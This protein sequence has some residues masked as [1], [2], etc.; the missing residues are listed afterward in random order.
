MLGTFIVKPSYILDSW[1]TC[2]KKNLRDI[3]NIGYTYFT[4]HIIF[5]SKTH[6]YKVHGN[7]DIYVPDI[8]KYCLCL[9]GIVIYAA[10]WGGLCVYYMHIYQRFSWNVL[11]APFQIC[12]K[13]SFGHHFMYFELTIV[14]QAYY[15]LASY[16]LCNTFYFVYKLWMQ[17]SV[18]L[19]TTMFMN[20]WILLLT[21]KFW[22]D[23]D[24]HVH[25]YGSLFILLTICDYKLGLIHYMI[26]LF[27]H[28]GIHLIHYFYLHFL[29][30]YIKDCWKDR[31]F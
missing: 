21:F 5:F 23:H 2:T 9:K 16:D 25:V 1:Y 24:L 19:F 14:M 11:I 6:S 3:H 4:V 12:T 22:F 15:I 13:I 29:L 30:N 20:A 18:N 26:K 31:I 10:F 17:C 7:Q 27:I 28:Y 8:K